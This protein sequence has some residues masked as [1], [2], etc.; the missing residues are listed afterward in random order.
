VGIAL[1]T[2]MLAAWH[3]GLGTC[4]LAAAVIYPDVLRSLLNI[5]ESKRIIVGVAIGYP[6]FSNPAVKFR[7]GREALDALVTWHG[8]S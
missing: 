8:V 6:D 4:A 7:A 5:P 2:L 3:H 1:Q